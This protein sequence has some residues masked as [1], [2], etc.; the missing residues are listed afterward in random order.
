MIRKCGVNFRDATHKKRVISHFSILFIFD[1][2]LK[3]KLIDLV[4]LIW[5]NLVQIIFQGL[6]EMMILVWKYHRN[7]SLCIDP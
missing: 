3:N 1:T 4:Q 7:F 5:F 6:S 2:K